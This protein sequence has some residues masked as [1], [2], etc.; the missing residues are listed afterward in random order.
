MTQPASQAALSAMLALV[1]VVLVLTA[2]GLF[3]PD[4]AVRW[5]SLASNSGY[6]GAR[7]IVSA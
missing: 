7:R 1:V 5:A 2:A 3:R 6:Y 4:T